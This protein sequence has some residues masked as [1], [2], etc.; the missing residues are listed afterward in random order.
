MTVP[1][2]AV[3]ELVVATYNI[4]SATLDRGSLV[5]VLRDLAPDVLVV[6]EGPNHLRWRSAAARLARESGLL[7]LDGGR[8]AGTN[9]LFAR[10]RVDT[11]ATWARRWPTP[12]RDP[13]RGIVGGL[14]RCSGQL[15]GVVGAHYPLQPDDRLR[16]GEQVVAAVAEFRR[17]APTVFV[18][19]DVNEDPGGPVWQQL[20]AAGLTDSA[21]GAAGVTDREVDRG[22]S[23]T[24]PAWQ[25]AHRIDTLWWT[26]EARILAAGVPVT[27]AADGAAMRAASDHLPWR[28]RAGL[29]VP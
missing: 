21:G 25:P 7:Y 12:P 4:K 6:Q 27:A 3:G 17:R 11:V 23:S 24:F 18:G 14:L 16:Y 19:A 2:A 20:E 29:G 8:P 5:A 13:V 1:A 26:G 22:Q 10:M 15:F 28:V 9:M